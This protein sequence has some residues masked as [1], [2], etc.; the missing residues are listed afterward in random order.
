MFLR[1]CWYIAAEP[2][3][4]GRQ[5]LGRILLSEPVVLYRKEDGTVVALEDRCCHRRAPLHKGRVL[6][7]ALQCGY[8]GF[9]YDPGGACIKVPGDDRPP[10]NARVRSYPVRE[11]HRWIWIWMGDAARADESLIPDFRQNDDPA[12]ASAHA[13]MHIAAN[14]LLIVDNLMDLSHVA[15][16]HG[17]TIGSDD[18]RADLRYGRGD[19]FVRGIRASTDIESPP[20]YR[21]LGFPPLAAQTKIMTFKPS[22]NVWIEITTTEARRGAAG[23][24]PSR[25]AHIFVL[26]SI[27]P[28]TERSS[29]YF[30]ANARDF[31][32]DNVQMTEF[33]QRETIN[34]FNEDKD[35]LEAQQKCIDLD[36]EAPIVS[37]G[38]DA[39]SVY[40]RRMMAL[41][42]EE[43]ARERV[44][45]HT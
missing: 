17:A 26:N 39:G 28:E 45:A 41:L 27:T 19:G 11:R 23:Q 36:P 10:P 38:G 18:S 24:G 4:V 5:P 8:H 43:E 3:E 40:A 37:V 34:A 12:W 35:M 22:A 2:G 25:S 32:V 6:G 30:W 31:E 15:F 1:N 16:V 13:R 44:I 9:V 33:F 14:Y 29:Y 42:V 20:I 21:K 7:D